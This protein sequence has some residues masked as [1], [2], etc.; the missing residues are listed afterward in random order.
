MQT[1]KAAAALKAASGA[2]AV[3][4]IQLNITTTRRRAR[5]LYLPAFIVNYTCEGFR[6]GLTYR[7]EQTHA[8]TTSCRSLASLQVQCDNSHCANKRC[9]VCSA[10]V[11]YIVPSARGPMVL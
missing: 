1:A 6:S 9:R 8:L 5:V 7:F 4:D 2:D 10:A 11:P 3:K